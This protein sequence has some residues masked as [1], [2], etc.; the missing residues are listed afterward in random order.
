MPFAAAATVIGAGAAIYGA[1]KSAD[2]LESAGEDSNATQL[3]MYN[4]SRDDQEPFRDAGYS[5][6]EQ[7]RAGLGLGTTGTNASNGKPT[8]ENFDVDAYLAANSDVAKNPNWAPL[9]Y[10][11]YLQHGKD[12]GRQFTYKPGTEPQAAG[13]GTANTGVGDLNRNFSMADYQADPGYKFRLDQG[14]QALERSAAAR[15]GLLSGG[16][17][18]DLTDYQQGSASQE[19]GNAFNRFNTEQDKRFNR[20]ASLAGVGQTATNTIN[21]IGTQTAQNIGQTQQSIGNARAS[22]YV[23]AANGATSAIGN[24]IN[25][26]QNQK[27]LDKIGP[28]AANDDYSSVDN[29]KYFGTG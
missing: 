12:E 4:Q 17:L 1:N 10:Q 23:G 21:N 7:L 11:H 13:A 22:G 2:A 19:Y 15:G 6:L 9:A 5:A 14:T 8:E 25:Q 3:Q 18:K 28:N 20:L 26:Y 29:F 27:L 24:G 16:T